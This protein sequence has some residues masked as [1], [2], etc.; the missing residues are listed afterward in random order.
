M[1]KIMFE[2]RDSDIV[3][4]HVAIDNPMSQNFDFHTHDI[5]ELLFLKKGNVS[6]VSGAKVYKM[7]K[8]SLVIF[9][10]NMPHKIRVDDNTVYE[11]YNIL[12]NENIMANRIFYKLPKNL[13]IINCT[14]NNIICDLFKK[15]DYYFECFTGDDLKRIIS[16][17]I[18]E[19]VFNMYL[20]PNEDMQSST[21]TTHPIISAAMKY[22]NKHYA[23]PI[24]IEDICRKVGVTKS[25]L[26][27]LFMEYVNISPKKFINIKRLSKAQSL[28]RM[29]ERPSKIYLSCG[30]NDYGT[31][32]RNYV[33]YF[34]YAPSKK[35]EIAEERKIYL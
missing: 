24:G 34:G 5:C 16:N 35:E 20:L 9:R 19:I 22:I 17:T 2:L 21:A 25:H 3:C 29:G 7:Q 15:L 8:D 10:A 27:H 4:T 32:F 11:R 1:N 26:H 18:E 23:E 6:A 31:F 30:F 13:D 33:S 12:F 28:I 14:D